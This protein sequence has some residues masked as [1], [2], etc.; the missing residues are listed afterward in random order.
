MA[1]ISKE[2]LHLFHK[3]HREVFCFLIFKLHRDLAQSL[4]IMS[5]WIWLEHNGYPDINHKM[6]A[7]PHNLVNALV[8]EVVS[9]LGCLEAEDPHIPNNGGLPLTKGLT[10]KD[11]SLKIFCQKRYTIIAG[12]K[13]VLKNICARIFADVL[14]IILKSRNINKVR[15][16][17]GNI[18]NMHLIIPGFPHPLFGTFD[19]PT[20]D[21]IN[22]DLSDEKIWMG[23]GPCD[24]VTDDDKSMFLTFS[25]GFPVSE[26]EVKQLFTRSYGDCVQS[27]TMGN[28]IVNNQSLFA[29]MILK[30]VRTVDQILNGRRVAKLQINGK[31]I[32]VQFF[33]SQN[34]LSTILSSSSLGEVE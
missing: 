4:L 26:F 20:D 13:S 16:S 3:S 2:E 22:L 33:K 14:E 18:S 24:D 32:W 34:I 7:L 15:A 10:Q 29:M 8:T 31:H 1:P 6:M 5:L 17:Q 19:I 9:C 21:T 30:S 12:I 25:K 27:L 28:A 11:I 23:N